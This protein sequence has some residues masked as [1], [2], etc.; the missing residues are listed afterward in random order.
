[1][2]DFDTNP[3]RPDPLPGEYGS[4]V[5][6]F[7]AWGERLDSMIGREDWKPSRVDWM[8]F[9]PPSQTRD[10]MIRWGEKYPQVIGQIREFLDH[11]ER[12]FADFLRVQS[13]I[14]CPECGSSD[15]LE[16][17]DGWLHCRECDKRTGLTRHPLHM[18]ESA[19]DRVAGAYCSLARVILV[20]AETIESAERGPN[21]MA[22]PAQRQWPEEETLATAR[23]LLDNGTIT[24]QMREILQA[25]YDG[26]GKTDFESL[27]QQISGGDDESYKSRQRDLNTI[28]KDHGIKVKKPRRD[29][30][31][32]LVAIEK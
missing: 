29:D 16:F 1:M 7:R 18:V 10:A 15:D 13:P 28:L 11:A 23:R 17:S 21:D 25:V 3:P 26:N 20:A 5:W 2:D 9:R 24:G 8:V 30:F 32:Y 27:K 4:D 14:E 12:A 31:L 22:T 19:T 6:S